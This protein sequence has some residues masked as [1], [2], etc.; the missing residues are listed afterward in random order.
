[1]NLALAPAEDRYIPLDAVET[2]A[3]F[4]VNGWPDNALFDKTVRELVSRARKDGRRVRMFGEMV[5][6]LWA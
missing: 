6:A 4:I 2:P 5:A 3:K 1:M